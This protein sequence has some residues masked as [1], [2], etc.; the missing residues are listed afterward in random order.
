VHACNLRSAKVLRS[1]FTWRAAEG[2]RPPRIQFDPTEIAA[3]SEMTAAFRQMQQ[4]IEGRRQ[5][6]TDPWDQL[7]RILVAGTTCCVTFGPMWIGVGQ[8]IEAAASAKGLGKTETFWLRNVVSAGFCAFADQFFAAACKHFSVLV[9]GALLGQISRMR[10]AHLC[11]KRRLGGIEAKLDWRG[12]EVSRCCGGGCD[13][14][15]EDYRC[16]QGR[17][18]LLT[19][20]RTPHRHT[21][22]RS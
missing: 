2:D 3:N 9:G 4:N 10:R 19:F 12:A 20:L 21:R 5:R 6:Q 18:H 22:D 7:R 13:P 1:A 15:G 17:G 8:G 14:E 11:C 16:V